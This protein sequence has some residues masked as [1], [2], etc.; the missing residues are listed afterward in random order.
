MNYRD[1][2]TSRRK[3]NQQPPKSSNNQPF[4]HTPDQKQKPQ[5]HLPSKSGRARSHSSL[6]NDDYTTARSLLKFI[7]TKPDEYQKLVEKQGIFD[8]AKLIQRDSNQLPPPTADKTV[9]A[10]AIFVALE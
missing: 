8:L 1:K 6:F 4:P 3:P 9:S 10:K 7:Q 5:L 2:A